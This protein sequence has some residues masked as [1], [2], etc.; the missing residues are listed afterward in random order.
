MLFLLDTNAFSDLMQEQPAISTRL[1]NIGQ[2]DK[3][4]I[5]PITR[6]EIRFGIELQP[7][8]KRRQALEYKAAKVFASV[9]CLAMPDTAGDNYGMLKRICRQQGLALDENDLWIAATALSLSAVLVTRDKDFANVNGL[10]VEDW[11][12]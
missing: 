6:G 1:S 3:V 2:T 7:Q 4:A 8:G 5:C 12:L 10:K 9:P 11:T